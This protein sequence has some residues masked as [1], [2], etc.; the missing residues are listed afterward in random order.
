VHDLIVIEAGA[1]EVVRAAPL[2]ASEASVVTYG[3]GGSPASSAF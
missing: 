3:P 2:N 1:I